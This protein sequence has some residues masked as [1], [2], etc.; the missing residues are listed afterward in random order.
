MVARLNKAQL[1][2]SSEIVPAPE[3]AAWQDYN[4]GLPPV[5][6]FATGAL[7]LAFVSVLSLAFANPEMA[8]PFGVF[9]AF[10]GA[11][12]AVPAIF[13]RSAPEGSAR[14]SRWAD[15]M[16]NGIAVEHGRCTGR[17]AT[18]LVLMLPVLILGWAIAIATIAALV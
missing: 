13:S 8:V 10:I 5:L 17:E 18:V 3:A 1:L 12:F 9:A 2:A 7:F 4:F 6:H 15:F 11:F 14:A 16:E